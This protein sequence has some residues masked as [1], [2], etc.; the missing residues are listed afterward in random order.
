ML[1]KNPNFS[2]WP[3]GC[4]WASSGVL[5]FGLQRYTLPRYN[6]RFDMLTM[7]ISSGLEAGQFSKVKKCF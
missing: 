5:K 6:E 7:E 2:N 1:A 4:L 3:T